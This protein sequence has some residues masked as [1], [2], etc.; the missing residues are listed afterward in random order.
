VQSFAYDDQLD[1]I[2]HYKIYPEMKVWIGCN[3]PSNANK[4]LL[5]GESHYL[6]KESDFHHDP[7]TWYAGI[8]VTGKS[9]Y[10]W[11][12]T[13]SI[14]FN[15]INTKWR[16]KSKSIYRNI[17][18][19]LFES[20]MF[21]EKP[22]TAFT[23]VAF[24]NYFQRPAEKTGQSIKVSAL[25]AKLGFDVFKNVVEAI[26]PS[27]VLFTSSLALHHAKKSGIEVFLKRNNISFDRAPHPGMPWW[28]RRSKAYNNKTGKE[29]F[30]TFVNNEVARTSSIP[31]PI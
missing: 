13:R 25:D 21:D 20:T 22:L 19:A 24:M 27:M 5:I 12:K 17:E 26:S 16:T 23:E 2:D 29:H 31:S 4:L 28:N 14:I 8:S 15:G 18:K 10:G 11:L 1:L 3:Y 6:K 7:A 30:I 9:D